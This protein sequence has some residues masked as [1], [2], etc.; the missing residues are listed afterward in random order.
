[1]A[2][3]ISSRD[4]NQDVGRAKRMADEAPVIIT[5]RGKAA[6]VLMTHATFE[7]LTDADSAMHAARLHAGRTKLD[8]DRLVAATARAHGM[9][10]VTRN[11]RDFARLGVPVVD[12]FSG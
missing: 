11:S 9:T 3:Q 7:R 5:D 12:P 8:T 6:Y 4:F 2:A 10:I 1:M